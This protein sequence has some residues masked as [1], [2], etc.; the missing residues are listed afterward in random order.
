MRVIAI[1]FREQVTNL[2]RRAARAMPGPMLIRLGVWGSAIAAY[3]VAMPDD[4]V[5]TLRGALGLAVLAVLPAL[6]PRGPV[7]TATI[8]VAVV[9]WILATTAYFEPITSYRLTALAGLLYLLHTSAALAAVVPY[10]AVVSPG[11]L[12]RWLV[13][14]AGV[15]A[16]TAL[17]GAGAFAGARLVPA[18]TFVIASVA[19][20][21]LAGVFAWLSTRSAR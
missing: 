8:V 12:A 16:V 21:A 14:A 19:G 7:V 18:E 9:G 6:F 2:R 1:F 20:V 17:F 15:V 4:V 3:L 5:F 10:D 11:V 13:R